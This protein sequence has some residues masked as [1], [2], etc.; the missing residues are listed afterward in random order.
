MPVER[1]TGVYT[2]A[3]E[4][5]ARKPEA[6]VSYRLTEADVPYQL[7]LH[8]LTVDEAYPRLERYIN[9]AAKTNTDKVIIIHGGGRGILREMVRT[10]LQQIPVVDSYGPGDFYEGGDNVTVVRLKPQE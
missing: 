4:T 5:A 2:P 6:R 3:P 8:G 9:D 10:Y 1:V 7:D